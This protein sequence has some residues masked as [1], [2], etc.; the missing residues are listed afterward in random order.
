ML[1]PIPATYVGIQT[2]PHPSR[3][4]SL[5]LYNILEEIPGH[6]AGSTVSLN[7]LNTE[8]YHPVEVSK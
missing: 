3:Y 4:P 5:L 6:P 8:G 1:T 7:T 2:W